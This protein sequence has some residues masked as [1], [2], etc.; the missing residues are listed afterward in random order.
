MKKRIMPLLL[1]ALLLTA[2]TYRKPV[3]VSVG[4]GQPDSVW[5]IIKVDTSTLDTA[6]WKAFPIDS[7]VTVPDTAP[8]TVTYWFF[9]DDVNDKDSVFSTVEFLPDAAGGTGLDSATT[10]RLIKMST[11]GIGAGADSSLRTERRIQYAD[12][13]GYNLTEQGGIAGA[14]IP[15]YVYTVDTTGTGLTDGTGD[16][17]S[18]ASTTLEDAT[19]NPKDGGPTNANGQIQFTVTTGTWTVIAAQNGFHFDD[20]TYLVTT[21]DTVAIMGYAIS[22]PPATVANTCNVQ[23]TVRKIDGTALQFADV[24]LTLPENVRNTCDTTIVMA[25]IIRTATDVNGQFN[26]DLIWSACMDNAKYTI[27]IEHPDYSSIKDKLTV[28]STATLALEWGK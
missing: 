3:F 6:K 21:N 12:T 28:P 23:G 17:I 16:S 25:R 14:T 5:A 27:T 20:S 13:I 19:G 8:V 11:W 15:F 24:T 1:L 10:V 18:I 22:I 7:F 9:Y 2:G 26:Q 4:D